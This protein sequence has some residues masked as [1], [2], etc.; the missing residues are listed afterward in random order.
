[1]GPSGLVGVGAEEVLRFG[2]TLA[3]S[4]L[5]GEC[6]GCGDIEVLERCL[7]AFGNGDAGAT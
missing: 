3:P 1:M 7:E 6:W 5:A 4:G 2:S